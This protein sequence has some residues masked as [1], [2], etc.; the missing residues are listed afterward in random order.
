MA[1]RLTA[2]G[3]A[4]ALGGGLLVALGSPALAANCTAAQLIP[5]VLAS[6]VTEG[7]STYTPLIRGKSAVVRFYLAQPTC[8]VTTSQS[9][10]INSATLAVSLGGAAPTSLSTADP[11]RGHEA[12]AADDARGEQ[13]G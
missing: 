4:L 8:T 7:L 3:T 1:S 10:T 11:G 9:I 2:A 12:D 5:R 13:R 6:T